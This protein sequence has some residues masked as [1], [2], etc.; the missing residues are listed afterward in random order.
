[1]HCSQNARAS[2][3]SV[4]IDQPPNGASIGHQSQSPVEHVLPIRAR[5]ISLC[6]PLNHEISQKRRAIEAP[7]PSHNE[8]AT[9]STSLLDNF[10][11]QFRAMSRS[12][13][14]LVVH[15]KTAEL[16]IYK[17]N[18]EKY[19][20]LCA[21]LQSRLDAVKNLETEHKILKSK[22]DEMQHSNAQKDREYADLRR[23]CDRFISDYQR[24]SVDGCSEA[25]VH[26]TTVMETHIRY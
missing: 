4:S 12:K 6:A 13:L 26:N 9:C 17:N 11:D 21:V 8:V 24:G 19:E 7:S 20:K 3:R 25:K 14:E 16:E 18:F 23:N 2:K 22:W 15:L 1:M 5:N 10:G